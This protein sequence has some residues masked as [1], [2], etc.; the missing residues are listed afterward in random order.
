MERGDR[1]A[2]ADAQL[3]IVV[4]K[5]CF[6]SDHQCLETDRGVLRLSSSLSSVLSPEPK[7]SDDI[8]FNDHWITRNSQNLLWLPYDYRECLALKDNLFVIGQF[9]GMVNFIEFSFKSVMMIDRPKI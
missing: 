3:N 8:F 7:S 2:D 4:S 6:S 1:R 9:S 5:L